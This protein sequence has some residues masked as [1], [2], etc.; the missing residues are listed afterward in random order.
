MHRFGKGFDFYRIITAIRRSILSGPANET[1]FADVAHRQFLKRIAGTLVDDSDP[2][3]ELDQ[4][5]HLLQTREYP[6]R[7]SPRLVCTHRLGA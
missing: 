2:D 5:Q 7:R 4:L 1:S 3:I 6:S